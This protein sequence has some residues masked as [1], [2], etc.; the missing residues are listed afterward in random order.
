NHRTRSASRANDCALRVGERAKAPFQTGDKCRRIS[1]VAAELIAGD[2]DR[3]DRA[4]LFGCGVDPIEMLNNRSFMR[5]SYAQAAQVPI[6]LTRTLPNHP[7]KEA[8][9]IVHLKRNEDGV[10][11]GLSKSGVVNVRRK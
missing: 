11:I 4:D 2:N 1:V 3:V 8:V 10:H 6:N 9:K 7:P 5:R